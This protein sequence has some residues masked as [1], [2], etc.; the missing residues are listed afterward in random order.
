MGLDKGF[1]IN[2]SANELRTNRRN[3]LKWV[4]RLTL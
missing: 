1:A 4:E 3:P 2:P